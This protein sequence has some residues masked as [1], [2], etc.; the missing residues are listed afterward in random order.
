MKITFDLDDLMLP[1][2]FDINIYNRIINKEL[3]NHIDQFGKVIN[4]KNLCNL[5]L[6]LFDDLLC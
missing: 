4:K 6:N 3:R 2:K 1:Y 5:S